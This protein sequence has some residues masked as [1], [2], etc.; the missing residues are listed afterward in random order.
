[1]TQVSGLPAMTPSFHLKPYT[2]LDTDNGFNASTGM[3]GNVSRLWLPGHDGAC[4]VVSPI[5]K[6]LLAIGSQRVSWS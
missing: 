6:V 1:M 5:F 2:E 4:R 3:L